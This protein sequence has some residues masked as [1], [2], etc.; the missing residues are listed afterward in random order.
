[1]PS[2][3]VALVPDS[4][5][6]AEMRAAHARQQADAAAY[7]A[8]ANALAADFDALEAKWRTEWPRIKRGGFRIARPCRPRSTRPRSPRPAIRVRV[9]PASANRDGP[10]EPDPD[11][12]PPPG[13]RRRAG[14]S[15]WE[16]AA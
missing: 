3:R 11:L 5:A 13:A 1:V 9:R 15:A 4:E 8:R 10:S 7:R 14:V 12:D 2:D 6:V 16:E